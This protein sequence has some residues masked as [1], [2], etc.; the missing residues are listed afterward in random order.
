VTKAQTKTRDESALPLEGETVVETRQE[1]VE[2][3][4]SAPMSEAAAVVSMIERAARDPA[5]DIGKLQQLMEMRDRI[6][7]KASE[8]AFDLAMTKAQ[9]EMRAVAADSNN[10][11][12]KSKY[13]SYF[14]LDKALR[15]TY[16]KCGFSLSFNTG[17]A[18][19][20]MVRVICR[21]AHNDGHGRD[22]HIDMPADGKGAKGGDVM[23][24]THAT[25]SAISYGMRYLLK[26]I[27]NIAVGEDDDGNAASGDPITEQQVEVIQG[28][29]V[30]S[31]ADIP[32]FCAYL[33]VERVE[34]IPAKKFDAAVAMLKKKKEAKS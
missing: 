33:K 31:G 19:E 25:G 21:V 28:L 22:Y 14:A 7:A 15:P 20:S 8:K 16:T 10:P 24:K 3:R 29:I 2:H 32:R 34:D 6:E 11:Q 4:P 18:P 26:M 5:V 1:I 23:T 9:S 30:E 17:D 13:A 27:F 12:T